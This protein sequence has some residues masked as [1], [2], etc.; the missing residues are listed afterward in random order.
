MI[1]KWSVEK[2]AINISFNFPVDK[3]INPSQFKVQQWNYKWAHSYGSKQYKRDGKPGKETMT[4][5][6]I[7]VSTDGNSLK[8]IIPD[9]TQVNQ[10]EA[11][12]SI[13]TATGQAFNETLWMTIN[14]IP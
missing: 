3:S 12:L 14:K 1:N 9:L 10:V 4:I 5:K 6:N 11:K 7:I 2:G 8:L 13:K